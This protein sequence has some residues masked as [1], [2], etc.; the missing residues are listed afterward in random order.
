MTDQKYLKNLSKDDLL[1][2]SVLSLKSGNYITVKDID[3]LDKK[4]ITKESL[5]GHDKDIMFEVCKHSR[6]EAL[7][8]LKN[9][10]FDLGAKDNEGNTC[11]HHAAKWG[12][13]DVKYF[14]NVHIPDY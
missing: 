5:I 9:K 1:R 7:E 6:I 8:I 10:S 2:F 4:L 12:N 14:E 11:L 3:T 13:I